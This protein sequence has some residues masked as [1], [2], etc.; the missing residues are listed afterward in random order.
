VLRRPR[1]ALLLA[2]VL[3]VSL[4]VT[5]VAQDLEAELEEAEGRVEGLR[6]E[7][8]DATEAYETTWARI[9]TLRVE[10]QDLLV[11]AEDLE[12]ELADASA[13]L[14]DRAVAMFKRGQ[15]DTSLFLLAAEGPGEAA[16]RA[17]LLSALQTRDRARAERAGAL[18]QA[19]TQTEQLLA[20]RAAQLEQLQAQLDRQRDELARDL[21]RAETV[22]DDL[23]QRAQN[24][25][26]IDR[27]AQQGVYS[28]IFGP[29]RSNFRDTFGAPRSG[30]RSH[31][32]TDVFALMGEPVLAIT[33]GTIARHSN[34]G[35]G[36][37]SVYLQ[38]DDGNLYYYTHLQRIDANGAVGRRVQGGELIAYN[39]DTGNARG[40]APHVHF[41]IKPGGGA[42]INPYP[43]LAAACF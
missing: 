11:R 25:R 33:D 5:A 40:G 22:A 36:G 42:S 26:R 12:V 24:R 15:S 21:D 14:T 37:I 28:C 23:E 39:G 4:P 31:K 20:D 10:Q 41:E 34:G 13:A 3:A 6:G 38:G 32:G 2:V 19:L 27:G 7:L 1:R 18:R 35:L 30:G 8:S 9:E 16:D 43:W 17:A 29:G